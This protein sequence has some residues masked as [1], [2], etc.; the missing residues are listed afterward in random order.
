M[1]HDQA[2]GIMDHMTSHDQSTYFS[3]CKIYHMTNHLGNV[4][5]TQLEVQC[6]D[7]VEYLR[8]NV[9][10]DLISEDLGR[11]LVCLQGTLGGAGRWYTRS[12]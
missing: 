3:I 2:V 6:S 7:V 5:A 12:Q 8:G 1:S 9:C 11:L 4:E 10:S